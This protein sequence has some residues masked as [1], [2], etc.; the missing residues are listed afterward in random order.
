MKIGIEIKFLLNGAR[1]LIDF[2]RRFEQSGRGGD[3]QNAFCLLKISPIRQRIC[4]LIIPGDIVTENYEASKFT[5]S[6][7]GFDEWEDMAPVRSSG[8]LCERLASSPR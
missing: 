3:S 7:R 4:K 5:R 1:V 6:E 2:E 8:R